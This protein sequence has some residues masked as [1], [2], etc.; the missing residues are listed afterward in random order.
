MLTVSIYIPLWF[1]AIKGASAMQSGINTIPLV[2]SVV[3]GSIMSGGFVQRIGYYTP[4]MILGSLFM[5]IGA[6]LI[7]TWS[8]N[9]NNSI[10]IGTQIVTGFGVGCTMQHPNIAVQTVLDKPDVPIGTAVLSLFQ[11]L[12]GAVFTAVGQS[13]HRQVLCRPGTNRRSKSSTHLS[14]RS[15][16]PD[17]GF[18]SSNQTNDTGSLQRLADSWDILC[19]THH[20]LPCNTSCSRHGMAQRER[21]VGHACTAQR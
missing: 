11:T 8:V 14:R 16:G 10:W 17:D 3:V 5:A 6:G 12:G 15:H 2:L 18:Y 21:K 19:G 7:T 1:Q 9:T 4:F 20:R 13:L